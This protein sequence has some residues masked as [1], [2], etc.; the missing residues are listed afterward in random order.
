V[1]Y[2]EST[3]YNGV[4]STSGTSG[5]VDIDFIDVCPPIPRP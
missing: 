1:T 5:A 2:Q 3:T 4:Y